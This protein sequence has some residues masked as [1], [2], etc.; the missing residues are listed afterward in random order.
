MAHRS[1][2]RIAAAHCL[3]RI[4]AVTPSYQPPRRYA[5]AT[6]S[7]D[8]PR[9]RADYIRRYGHNDRVARNRAGPVRIGFSL[10]RIAN[11]PLLALASLLLPAGMLAARDAVLRHVE[12]RAHR[13][14]RHRARRR[15]GPAAPWRWV[16]SNPN[17]SEPLLSLSDA[18]VFDALAHGERLRERSVR[19]GGLVVGEICLAPDLG[20]IGL[21]P[22]VLAVG[23]GRV[24]RELCGC[25]DALRAGFPPKLIA[26]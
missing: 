1:A 16:R 14:D 11:A 15:P 18:R 19:E 6:S 12:A 17:L 4:C 10:Q 26:P 13:G 22:G 23:R 3:I 7:S 20:G 8:D 25:L 21:A 5:P 24:L 9:L 2:H